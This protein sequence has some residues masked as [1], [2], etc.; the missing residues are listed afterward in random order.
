[1][2][3]AANM[4]EKIRQE[5]DQ[6]PCHSRH[7]DEQSKEDKEWN[8]EQDKMAHALVDAA[9]QHRQWAVGRQSK[10][11]ENR[12]TEGKRDWHAGKNCNRNHADKKD[13]Q[14]EIPKAMKQR[15]GNPEQ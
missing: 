1:M 14:I 6:G 13:Q 12:K 9:D 5:A 4:S 2:Q 10:I 8:G 11:A 15:P 3:P 7:F